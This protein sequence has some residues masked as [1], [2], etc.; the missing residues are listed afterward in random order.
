MA[1]IYKDH[2]HLAIPTITISKRGSLVS[3][4]SKLPIEILQ[5]V[6]IALQKML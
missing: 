6:R 2:N 3:C 4:S 1:L 5:H